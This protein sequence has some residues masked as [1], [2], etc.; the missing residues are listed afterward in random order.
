K[1]GSA[2]VGKAQLGVSQRRSMQVDAIQVG[3]T[4]NALPPLALNGQNNGS[5]FT[6]NYLYHAPLFLPCGPCLYQQLYD[7]RAV[8]FSGVPEGCVS[9]VRST[10]LRVRSGCQ[11]QA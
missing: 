7:A 4:Q 10:A 8:P 1:V 2:Q 9:V 11:Q 6:V 3:I 5:S